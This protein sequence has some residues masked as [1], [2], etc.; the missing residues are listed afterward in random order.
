MIESD[1]ADGTAASVVGFTKKG[2]FFYIIVVCVSVFCEMI[3]WIREV[4]RD[5]LWDSSS[6]QE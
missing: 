4:E 3:L 2:I 6:R 1:T 5:I